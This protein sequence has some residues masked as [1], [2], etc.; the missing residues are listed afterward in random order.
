MNFKF[1]SI[2]LY[3]ATPPWSIQMALQKRKNSAALSL[4]GPIQETGFHV[5]WRHLAASGGS[6]GATALVPRLQLRRFPADG[7][8]TPWKFLAS[9]G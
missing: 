6:R 1:A 8:R 5:R 4:P 3:L 9:L 2:I 7:A